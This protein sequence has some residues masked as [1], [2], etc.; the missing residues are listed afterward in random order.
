VTAQ[1]V[2]TKETN[3]IGYKVTRIIGVLLLVVG[4]AII[5]LRFMEGGHTVIHS[6]GS[7]GSFIGLGG[8]ML[9]LSF[10]LENK[11]KASSDPSDTPK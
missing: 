10:R 8:G 2:T 7:G 3:H 9:V 5:I 4:A 6:I 1:S 11:E